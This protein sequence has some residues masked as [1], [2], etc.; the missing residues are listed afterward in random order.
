MLAN[1]SEF[2]DWKHWLLYASAPWPYPSQSALL[3]LLS[4][5]KSID[6]QKT[7]YITKE[8]F[9]K[10]PLWFSIDKPKTP[11][12]LSQPQSYDRFFHLLEFWFELFSAP[13]TDEDGD[14]ELL[15]NYKSMLLYM[16]AVL[17]PYE[18]F[19]RALSVSQEAAMPRLNTKVQMRV[20]AFNTA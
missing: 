17:E 3:T 5:Y 11:E 2:V 10:V 20:P 18:G 6:T 9:M 16:S 15:L 8:T 7:D 4:K 19:L 12:E 1:G 13:I 14:E